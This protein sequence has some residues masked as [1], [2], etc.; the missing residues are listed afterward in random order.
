[1]RNYYIPYDEECKKVNYLF[2]LSL[3]KL[4]E[5][6]KKTYLYN[7]ISY[8]TIKDLTTR[9]NSN[10]KESILSEA[11]TSR[12]LQKDIYN[13]FYSVDRDKKI[14]TLNNNFRNQ[15]KDRVNKFV[16]INDKELSFL[17]A[18]ND[19]LLI[20][21]YLYLKY[22]CG[23]SS[24]NKIDTTAK[25]FLEASGY[26]PKAG[27]YISKISDYNKILNDN[28][29]IKITKKRDNNGNERNEYYIL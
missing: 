6:D 29:L 12:Y 3:Y 23:Y 14:I 11:T 8:D 10:C 16:I 24:S 15:N 13:R 4:A 28:G 2:V 1:M 21:Y 25:Q 22:Y 26:S 7:R 18:S 20:A 27:N 17:I 9:I 19:T 5:L